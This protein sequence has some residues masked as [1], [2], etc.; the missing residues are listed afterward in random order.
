MTA[1]RSIAQGVLRG[2]AL[3]LER[4]DFRNQ[5]PDQNRSFLMRIVIALRASAALVLVAAVA[6]PAVA[7][8]PATAGPAPAQICL[9]PAMVEAAPSGADPVAAVQ[10]AFS[11]F[12]N[13]PTLAVQ[14]LSSRLQ[15]QARQEA[16]LAGCQFVLFTTVRHERKTGGGF[17]GKMA[18]GAVQ[19][20]AW[21]ASGVSGGSTVGRVVAGAAAGAASSTINDYATASRQKDEFMLAY[22][23]EDAGGK[24]LVEDSDKRKAKSDGEDLLTPIA[25]KAAEAI[26]VSVAK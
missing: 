7:Q 13:G 23:L 3:L 14:P 9:A 10:D 12:L 26:A 6:A 22:R 15:S 4:N 5:S 8:E 17:L 11:G 21:V 1:L 25:Q 16:K 18:G 19:Q 20:G 2:H 24:V